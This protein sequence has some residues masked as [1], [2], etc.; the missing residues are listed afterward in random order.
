MSLQ[1]QINILK[2]GKFLSWRHED[3]IKLITK[4]MGAKYVLPISNTA[5]STKRA[6]K[7]NESV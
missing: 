3:D 5:D 4:E 2:K 1:A 7:K 6:Q